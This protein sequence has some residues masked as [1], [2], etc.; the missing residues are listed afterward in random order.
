MKTLRTIHLYLGTFF[1]PL[2]LAFAISGAWQLY[3]LNDAKKDG[4]YVP[5]RLV[6]KFSSLHRD[7]ILA[8][9]AGGGAALRAFCLAGAVLLVVSTILGIVMAYR[10]SRKP[11]AATICLLLGVAVPAVLVFVAK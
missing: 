3:R 4:S 7:Q 8:R 5:P 10:F 9:G 2:L 6:Q 11:L 1:A